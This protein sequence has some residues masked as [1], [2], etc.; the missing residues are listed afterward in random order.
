[1]TKNKHTNKKID[2]SLPRWFW[3]TL[4]SVVTIIVV[5]IIYLLVVRTGWPSYIQAV[6]TCDG[7]APVWASSF[8]NNSYIAPGD[9]HYTVPGPQGLSIRYYCTEQEAIDAGFTKKL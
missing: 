5:S 1:M 8:I 2:Y 9:D 6:Q 4:A 7:K 3:W